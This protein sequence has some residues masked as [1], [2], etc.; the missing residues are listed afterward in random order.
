MVITRAY[1][2]CILASGTG[3]AFGTAENGTTY[4]VYRY[5][6]LDHLSQIYLPTLISI[7]NLGL[8]GGIFLFFQILMEHSV[9]KQ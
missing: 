9:S 8:Y 6:P 3:N 7:S 4:D 2:D 1:E 5:E